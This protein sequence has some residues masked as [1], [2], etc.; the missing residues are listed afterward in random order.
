MAM[1]AAF[2]YNSVT[3]HSTYG[4][5]RMENRPDID[6][7][8][9]ME[10]KLEEALDEALKGYPDEKADSQKEDVDS[11]TEN[12]DSALDSGEDFDDDFVDG[13]LIDDDDDFAAADF[14]DDDAEE[15]EQPHLMFRRH[16][17]DSSD[18]Q[19]VPDFSGDEEAAPP[20]KSGEDE[21]AAALKEEKNL[22]GPESGENAA[23]SD[24]RNPDLQDAGRMASE[25]ADSVRRYAEFGKEED[26]DRQ[27]GSRYRRLL[28][29]AQQEQKERR[30]DEESHRAKSQTVRTSPEPPG[31]D[32]QD[33]EKPA[34]HPEQD[35]APE[36][37]AAMRAVSEERKKRH[38]EEV[39]R[40][41][42][43][44]AEARKKSEE[45]ED[46]SEE[47]FA[48]KLTDAAGKV[49]DWFRDGPV[50][51]F[52]R[53]WFSSRLAGP[54]FVVIIVVVAALAVYW[55]NRN[56]VYTSYSVIG[57]QE[58]QDTLSS[59]YACVSSGILRYGQEGATLYDFEAKR[60][61]D[62]KYSMNEPQ[63]TSSSN[64]MIA[65]YDRNGNSIVVADADG[66][67]GTF[68][69]ELPVLK[70]EVTDGGQVVCIQEDGDVT[71]IHYYRSDGTE[72]ASFRTSIDSPGY[73]L[74]IGIS[75]DGQLLAVSYLNFSGGNQQCV[76]DF[77]SFGSIGQNR[78]DNKIS[79]YTYE[80]NVIPEV[81]Y[82]GNSNCIAFRDDG[83]SVFS[84]TR[85]PEKKKD[86]TISGNIISSF[87]N[88]DHIGFVVDEG[89]GE[90][91]RL[92]VYNTDGDKEL[93]ML[94]DSE[95]QT[96]EISG[97]EI[98]FY[99]GAK[100]T[101]YHLSGVKKFEGSYSGTAKTIFSLGHYRFAAVTENSLEIIKLK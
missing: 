29:E 86:V 62:I 70:A 98:D 4:S 3:A 27:A 66:E 18:G 20:E 93:D 96:V 28:D 48:R 12:E 63:M 80:D 81:Q 7:Q 25:L 37:I 91:F 79:E 50:T 84:G 22:E 55:G 21:A 83:F 87:H 53:R 42:N 44:D 73:P 24:R 30:A 49:R 13:G 32:Q 34:V 90:N 85:I 14:L 97:D 64:G 75:A 71:W 47:A 51:R 61:W 69:T 26:A 6:G 95:Y 94:I 101:V 41:K 58:Q 68:S 92:L 45:E 43:R 65:L 76:V 67:A 82:F 5:E 35:A 46:A 89:S 31:K 74:D 36:Q 99:S 10:K 59:S 38:E 9:D 88:A 52:F 57:S 16:L 40:R 8:L 11:Q 100:I 17:L 19:E 72:I 23:D 2:G 60:I 39:L 77:Y 1:T 56:Y 15:I 78:M 54:S 33:Q